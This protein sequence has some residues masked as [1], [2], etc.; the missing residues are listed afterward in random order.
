MLFYCLPLLYIAYVI[1]TVRHCAWLLIDCSLLSD[2][3]RKEDL[4][5]ALLH[6]A[7]L[8]LVHM[9]MQFVHVH[10]LPRIFFC[11]GFTRFAIVQKL[12]TAELTRRKY[13][14][15]A[16]WAEVC[17]QVPMLCLFRNYALQ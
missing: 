5:S 8:D 11:G 12:I 17:L 6:S 13:T 1:L 10:K 15:H 9:V 4:A 2:D 7:V 14:L 3:F 16:S